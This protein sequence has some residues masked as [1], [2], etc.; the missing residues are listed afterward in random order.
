MP[1]FINAIHAIELP[2]RE[3]KIP[4]ERYQQYIDDLYK[5]HGGEAS[6]ETFVEGGQY[7]YAELGDSLFEQEQIKPLLLNLDMMI[8]AHWSQEFDPDYAACGPYF[9]HQ[10]QLT[11][12]VF[13]VCDMGS[14]APLMAL[15]LLI[16]YQKNGASKTGMVLCLEQ[17]TVPR[18]KSAGDIIPSTSGA[19]GVWV[20][21]TPT[22][23]SDQI[24]QVAIFPEKIVIDNVTRF[25][26]LIEQLLISHQVTL[27]ETQFLL[28]KNT[29]PWKLLNRAIQTRELSVTHE[30]LHFIN[31]QAGCLSA[32]TALSKLINTPSYRYTLLLDED[33]ETMMVGFAI[34]EQEI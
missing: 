34:L 23:H 33:V 7:T 20:S 30:Q 4:R 9:L 17:N 13:D 25:S 14:L 16:S 27:A 19:V 15:K 11:A 31:P 24:K 12:D 6:Q 26:D 5:L 8:I 1:S 10:H 32:M 18:E 2:S 29:L 22:A 3:K 28:R 21:Q